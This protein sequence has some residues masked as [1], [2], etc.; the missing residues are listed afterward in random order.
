[1]Y[2]NMSANSPPAGR[3]IRSNRPQTA[4]CGRNAP[5]SNAT[6]FSKRRKYTASSATPTPTDRELA[7]PAPATPI[8]WPVPHPAISTGA[9]TALSITVNTC[10]II[11]GC[12]IPVPRSAEPMA[13][14]GNCSAR[15]GRNQCK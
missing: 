4:G 14:S 3:P 10:T 7:S 1:M 2:K 8:A 9:S 6:Y 11:V 15:L 12:T 13:T 5:A